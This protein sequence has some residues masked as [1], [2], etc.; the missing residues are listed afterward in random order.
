[1]PSRGALTAL[2]A[3][4]YCRPARRLTAKF[5][6]CCLTVSLSLSR[7]TSLDIR[8][9]VVLAIAA[10]AL[11]PVAVFAPNGT[12]VLIVL[13]GATLALD[14]AHRRAALAMLGTIELT[15]LIAF[16]GL[17]AAAALWSFD[18]WRG[19]ALALRLALLFAAG[20]LLVSAAAAMQ[21][22]E[23]GIAHRGMALGGLLLVLLMLVETGSGAALTRFLRGLDESALQV[24]SNGA[25]LSRGGIALALFL[26]PCLAVLPAWYGR[27]SVPAVLFAAAAAL[28]LQPVEATVIAGVAGAAVFAAARLRPDA[29]WRRAGL[30]VVALLLVPPLVAALLPALYDATDLAALEQSHRHRVQIWTYA[31]ERIGERPLLGWGFDS[32]RELMGTGDGAAFA[33]APMSLHPHNATL[34]A[35]IELGLP[36]VAL[37]AALGYRLWRRAAGLA[38]PAAPAALAGIAATL[39]FT[40]ISRGAWQHWWLALLW[41]FAAWAVS[42]TRP[43]EP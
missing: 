34:Q 31:L 7:L 4:R 11:A 15:L 13:A 16:I 28:W 18:P 37:L 40:E 24:L 14:P 23:A 3:A 30:L 26:W 41:L 19:L 12:V 35:W 25:P 20:L 5:G 6:G 22:R 27:W 39:V 43:A 29:A 8:P 2:A 42:L 36:G 10:V 9:G 1:M 33:D 32:S 21:P 17:A 38:M